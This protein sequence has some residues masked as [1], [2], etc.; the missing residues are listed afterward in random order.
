[1]LRSLALKDYGLV[2]SAEIEFAGGA[3]MFTGETGSGKT[4]LLGALGF[5]LGE[6]TSADIVRRGAARAAVTLAFDPDESTRDRLKADGFPL[7][8]DEE[9]T[10]VREMSESGKS[11]LRL[12]GRLATASYVRELADG[13]AEIVGQHEAHRLL[14]PSYHL[15]L[16]DRFATAREDRERVV[17][18]HRAWTA[19][20][21]AVASFEGD[22]RRTLQRY[23]EAAF[24]LR[25]I[26]AAALEPGED[27]GLAERRRYL[28]N[29]ERIAGALRAAHEAL[30]ADEASATA[31]LGTAAASLQPI[32]EMSADLTEMAGEAAA[33][34]S[35]VTDLATQISRE[36][37]ATEFDAPE[38]EAI[39]ARLETIDRLK[40]KY[41]GSI[42]AIRR[43]AAEAR[44][45]VDDVE[46]R[47]GRRAE[48]SLAL[49]ESRRGLQDA[50]AALSERRRGAAERLAEKV[51]EEFAELALASGRFE[52]ALTP[53][54]DIGPNGAESV[55]FMFAANA[56]EPLRPLARVASGGERS[57]VLLALVVVL[58]SSRERTALVFDEIDGGVGGATAAAVGVRLG[59]LAREGQVVCVTHLAQLATW[60]ERHYVL[61]KHET[62]GQT[63]I[64]IR[65]IAADDDRAA[66][67]ARMLSGE[68][69]D[70]AL[71][72]ARTLL[73]A[74]R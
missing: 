39:N 41:G 49:A 48:L 64:A 25:E 45:I 63:S 18:A 57:R 46:N 53:A 52:V 11:T 5:A 73:K 14:Q 67:L 32:A 17:E 12:N 8:E 26:E 44:S 58:S 69:H 72:H 68:S 55:E 9:A 10:I 24:A 34:Q 62:N 16:L 37:D 56:G 15:E 31:A 35:Q 7:D 70:V 29:V 3:T 19:C 40:R 21:S 2:E 65:E 27:E 74:A 47:E 36:L 20:A 42:E 13:I 28:D 50:A 33:L 43:H 30:A 4:M 59:R 61:E 71:E 54:D 51:A 6:R 22:E 60:A 38:L 1:M 23:D 66:E